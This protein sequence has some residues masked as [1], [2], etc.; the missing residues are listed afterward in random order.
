[1]SCPF[2]ALDGVRLDYCYTPWQIVRSATGHMFRKSIVF[3]RLLLVLFL[4]GGCLMLR[5]DT[6]PGLTGRRSMRSLPRTTLWVWERPEDLSRIDS[7]TTAIAYLDQTIEVGSQVI[8]AP[9]RQAMVFPAAAVRIAVVRI[10]VKP[11]TDLAG[12]DGQGM[13]EEAAQLVLK[14]AAQP[15]ISALQIDFDATRSQRGFY[16]RLLGSVRRG[17][18]ADI[19]LSMTALASWCSGDDWIGSLPVDEAV[20]MFF[21]MEPDRGRAAAN[22]PEFRIREPLCETSIGVSTR[23]GWPD[24]MAGKRIYVFADRGWGADMAVLAERRLP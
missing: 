18:R 24:G 14:S 3:A 2:F 5:S 7:Q 16:R 10:E 9:R 20:P 1:M 21:R 13:A 23:E 8:S 17:M 12:A 11:G 4:A 22:R 15:G 19:P 6:S